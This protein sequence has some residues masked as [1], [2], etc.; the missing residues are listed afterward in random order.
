M[1]EYM[2]QPTKLTN[3]YEKGVFLFC[4]NAVFRILGRLL[5]LHY[6]TFCF[7]KMYLKVKK[8]LNML[9]YLKALCIDWMCDFINIL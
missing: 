2:L 4:P 1:V 8:K 5:A 9:D 3:F 7:L 6:M